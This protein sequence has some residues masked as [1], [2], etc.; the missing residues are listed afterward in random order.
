MKN[1]LTFICILTFS[2][3]YA[4]S[5]RQAEKYF[6]NYEYMKAADL[7]EKLYKKGDSSFTVI[8]RIADS[9]Y[10]N[11][12]T[13]EAEYWYTKLFELFTNVEIASEFYFK[14]AQSLKSNG[15]YIQSDKW[16][17]KFQEKESN[18]SRGKQLNKNKNYLSLYTKEPAKIVELHN[19]S[20]N[21]EYSDFGAF[22]FK[23]SLYFS[24]TRPDA[25]LS[26]QRL[27]KWNNQPFLDIYKGYEVST[28]GSEK[29]QLI[30]DISNAERLSVI[31]TKYHDASPVITKDGKT[32]YFTRDNYDKKL[33]S[34]KKGTVHLQL[35][36]A[37]KVDGQWVNVELLPFNNHAYSTGHP[38]LSLDEKTLYFVSDMPGSVGQT[39]I[40]KVRILSDGKY[41]TPQNLGNTINTEGREM[42]P[43]IS[44]DNIL[45]FSSDGHLG[46]G[47]LDI[48]SS[49]ISNDSY[50]GIKNIGSPFN[51]RKDDF[52]YTYLPSKN[53]G[54][55]SSNREGGKGDDDIYSF[56]IR[57]PVV[58]D[59][60]NQIVEGVVKDKFTGR[61]LPN[62]TVRLF[63]KK[64]NEIQKLVVGEDATFSFSLPCKESY[65]L[66]GVKPYYKPSEQNFL[67]GEGAGVLHTKKMNLELLD[68]FT[69]SQ[70]KEIIIKIN[71][72]YFDLNKSDIRPDA[73][74]ELDK[75]IRIMKKYPD[76][77]V[78]SGSHTDS[79]GSDAYNEK[80]SDRRA[81]STVSYIISKG[82]SSDRI[83]G[84]G[85]GETQPV[86]KCV[87]RV[88]CNEEAHQLNRRTEF[89]VVV[90]DK[91]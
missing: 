76:L 34:D 5:K 71:P 49:K 36:K 32:M 88:W 61:L 84:K 68:D 37:E 53:Y 62:S 15:K 89:V 83:S 59:T 17:L 57:K 78:E 10:Q 91:K 31:N 66:T 69:Y 9:Y 40:Y 65:K 1:L 35:Y 21:T 86:N 22:H 24:S 74:L 33:I 63:D 51:S 20:V 43:F 44:E 30:Y 56:T 60:C 80:L 11:T 28:K 7:Y 79:R 54:Y 50:E 19:L 87:N 8:S 3:S 73:A 82:I 67:T 41:G 16:L 42:F 58:K 29:S 2:M 18:D 38:A 6:T 72:I 48:F 70:D 25:T 12:K 77:I 39:D 46:L 14:Y 90:K 81:K 47:A 23:D 55:L 45:Y 52:A 26:K 4:Q 75:V 13:K 27:Y 85:Y 64:G